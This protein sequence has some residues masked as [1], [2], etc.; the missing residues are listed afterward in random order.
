MKYLNLCPE[1][2]N[3]HLHHSKTHQGVELEVTASSSPLVIITKKG[4][5]MENLADTLLTLIIVVM[6]FMIGNLHTRVKKL[7]DDSGR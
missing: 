2:F 6:V 4:K 3:Y 5:I 7:E 1:G